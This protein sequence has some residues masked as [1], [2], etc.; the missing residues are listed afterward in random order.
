VVK[1]LAEKNIKVVVL[2]IQPLS[3]TARE[4]HPPTNSLFD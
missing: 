1:L 2:D 3:Y 4:F